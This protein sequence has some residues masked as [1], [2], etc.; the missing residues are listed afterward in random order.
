[1]R[2]RGMLVLAIIAILLGSL[3]PISKPIELEDSK[4]KSFANSEPLVLEQFG[5][6]TN[7]VNGTSVGALP[8]GWVVSGNSRS[9]LT[10]SP[11]VQ[12]S[13]TSPYNSILDA[14]TYVA[15]MDDQGNWLWA[16]M[17]DASQG[18]TLLQTMEV[19]DGGDIY[20]GGFDFGSVAFNSQFTSTLLSQNG[21][22]DGFVAK[23]DPNGQW[24]WA[25]SFQHG[26]R[27]WKF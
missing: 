6:S 22:R 4:S 27:F 5:S 14:D 9:S 21:A 3:I 1:M 26:K 12:A 17:P 19:S 24:L 10:F 15:A 13:A 11:T 23:I 7:H 2:T 16:I 8:N 18:L 25:T 20:I